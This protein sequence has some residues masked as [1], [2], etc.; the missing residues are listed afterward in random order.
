M[1]EQTFDTQETALVDENEPTVAGSEAPAA[2]PVGAVQ[3]SG[4]PPLPEGVVSPIAAQNHLKTKG[5]VPADA[6]PQVMYGF[7]K[8]PGAG[9]ARF[10]VAHYDAT[11]TAHETPQVKEGI[12]VT[13]PGV[14]L[15]EVEGW[16]HKRQAAMKTRQEAKAA[17]AQAA[18]AKAAAPAA[19]ASATPVDPQADVPEGESVEAE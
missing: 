4:K 14:L 9:E 7:V 6:K 16:W 18:A 19:T 1:T 17:K 10:P 5:L 8:A 3:A 13:R 15:A 2:A 11:G 12:T